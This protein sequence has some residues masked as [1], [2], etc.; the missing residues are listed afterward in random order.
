MSAVLEAVQPPRE[1]SALR[2]IRPRSALI[3]NGWVNG[4]K[5]RLMIDTGC[6]Q[7][8]VKS[9][10]VN[11]LNIER[12]SM[13]LEVMNCNI[14]HTEGKAVLDR[15]SIGPEEV[16]IGI[17]KVHVLQRLPL[18]LDI[19]IG[20]DVISQRELQVVPPRVVVRLFQL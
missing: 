1:E 7:S 13:A 18:D 10:I 19:I 17:L 16:N 3:E 5:C 2:Q 4:R 14:I 8:L 12:G 9:D 20:W 15:E 11:S 6:S